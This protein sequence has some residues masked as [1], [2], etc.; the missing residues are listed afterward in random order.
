MTSAAPSA[1][2]GPSA[3]D[4]GSA[5]AETGAEWDAALYHTCVA[6]TDGSA[7]QSPALCH[8]LVAGL[9]SLPMS[10]KK[11]LRPHS[12]EVLAAIEQCQKH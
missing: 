7:A 4:T 3:A 10:R 12:H 9:Q 6:P 2:V 5:R 11:R 8:C 1:R